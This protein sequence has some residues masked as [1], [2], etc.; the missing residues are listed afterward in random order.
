[1][2]IPVIKQ[3]TMT[4]DNGHL[5]ITKE[6]DTYYVDYVNKLYKGSPFRCTVSYGSSWTPSEIARDSEVL[7]LIARVTGEN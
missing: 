2:R 4:V 6:G 7:K 1:M 3:V 5:E